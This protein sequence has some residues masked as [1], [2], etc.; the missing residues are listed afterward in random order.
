MKNIFLKLGLVL[1]IFALVISCESADDFAG[2]A[3]QTASSPSLSVALDF[4]NAQTLIEADNSYNFTVSISETQIANVD[5]KL[6][7]TG[8]TATRGS[9][10]DFP[11]SV[12]IPIGQTSASGVI[13]LLSDN[14][15]EDVETVEITIAT[16]AE[17]N[18]GSVSSEVV[19]FN[20]QNLVEGDLMVGLSW[21]AS[22]LTTD[23]GGNEIDPT[24]LADLRLLI[25]DV[26]Y[27]TV[28]DAAD[29]GSFESYTLSS[30]TPDGEYYVVADFYAAL[31]IPA[32]LNLTVTF[33]QT[34]VIN[35]DSQEYAAALSTGE[36]CAAA[37]YK[38]A[39]ITKTGDSYVIDPV[40]E[41]NATV[42]DLSSFVGEW[43][44][45]GSWSE[46]F[47]YTTEIVTTL[48]ANGDLWMNG[49]AFQWFEGWWGEVIVSSSA[50][51]LDVDQAT[52]IFTI[53]EQP[54]VETTYEGAPQAP[55]G[56]SGS[57]TFSGVC[58]ATPAIEIFAVLH[59]PGG[60]AA[61]F[62]G[63]EFG[64]PPFL[65]NVTL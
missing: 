35:G 56:L 58:A 60:Y 49:V 4:A 51:K 44:G 17:A 65:E 39:K 1:G 18:V 26:P 37:H 63:T 55:F 25:T 14:I 10:F 61:A 50:V 46:I 32:D 62:N 15:I 54:F 24:A 11:S 33:D 6:S 16:G 38:L 42:P 40:G 2:Q 30:A 34:G 23:N 7:Q 29:G 21:E 45:T 41:A 57:G 43:E 31:D 13:T 12:T 22:S 5:V 8:G 9:D 52:G 48:D 28:L 64:G 20:I 27:T 3:T 36:S 59:Q 19:T 53:A 47:G